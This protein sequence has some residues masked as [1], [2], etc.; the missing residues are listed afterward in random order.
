MEDGESL[1]NV[2][3]RTYV[4]DYEDFVRRYIAFDR[5][6]YYLPSRNKAVSLEI[7]AVLEIL[8]RA[9]QALKPDKP[10]VSIFL[11][12]GREITDLIQVPK[13]CRVLLFSRT[14]EFQGVQE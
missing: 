8:E 13:D 5:H 1:T 9:T 6:G 3:L 7:Q 11:V 12:D 10:F 14:G 2:S 4:L